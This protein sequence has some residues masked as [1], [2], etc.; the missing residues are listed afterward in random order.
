MPLLYVD[1]SFNKKEFWLSGLVIPENRACEL[2]DALDEVVHQ[3]AKSFGV[4]P[5]AELHGHDLAQGKN[6][7]AV[8]QALLRARLGVYRDALT[9]IRSTPDVRAF[10]YG[11]DRE[12]LKTK[13]RDPWPERQILL[14]HVVQRVHNWMGPEDYLVV[15]VDDFPAQDSMREHIRGLKVN[16]TYSRYNARPLK[17]IVDTLYFAPSNESRLLQ[18]SDLVSYMHFRARHPGS[19]ARAVKA[20]REMWEL[21]SLHCH[22]SMWDMT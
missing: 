18:A 13:Y 17:R 15:V 10:Q 3:A 21:V 20:A 9:A 4:S 19:E 16:G 7:W 1:E 12:K 8:M 22:S 6:D 5:R 11:L 14:G 2:E